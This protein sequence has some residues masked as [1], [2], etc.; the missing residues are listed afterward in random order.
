VTSADDRVAE[1]GVVN[2]NKSAL[3]FTP[4]LLTR[5]NR[6]NT[7]TFSDKYDDKF[8]RPNPKV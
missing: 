4:R 2:E 1:S 3:A 6:Q 7:I 5:S 8:R